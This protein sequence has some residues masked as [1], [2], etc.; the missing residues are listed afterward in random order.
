MKVNWS[1]RKKMIEKSQNELCMHTTFLF[2]LF[3][4]SSSLIAME[5]IVAISISISGCCQQLAL[6]AQELL[7]GG[8]VYMHNNPEYLWH[9]AVEDG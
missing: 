7:Y 9:V 3:V 1:K 5:E 2:L 4:I 8:P 6:A